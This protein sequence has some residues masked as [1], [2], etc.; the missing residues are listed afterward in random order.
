MHRTPVPWCLSFDRMRIVRCSVSIGLLACSLAVHASIFGDIKGLVHD[1]QHRPVAGAQITVKAIA[2]DWQKTASSDREGS[3]DIQ[4]V[5]IGQYQVTVTM[6]GF[7]EQS[8]TVLLRSG[9]ILDLHFALTVAQVKEQVEVHENQTLVDTASSTTSSTVE[10]QQITTTPGAERANSLAMITDFVPG[11]YVVHDQLHV[12]GGH[13]STWMLDGIPLPNTN[14]ATNVGPQIDP[15][16]IDTLEVQRG[17]LSAEYGDRIYGVFNAVTRSGFEASRQCDL[18]M[19]YGSYNQTDDQFSCGSH[20]E[21]FAY[22]ASL[23]G[24]RSD[25][26]LETPSP[27]VIH[28]MGAGLGGFLSL[29][30]NRTPADQLRFVASVRG[31][32]YQIPNTPEQQADGIRDVEDERD[33]FLNASWVHSGQNGLLFTLAPF[34]HLNRA[35][36]LGGPNDTPIS[37]ED[38]TR[39]DYAGGVTMLSLARGRHNAH[40]GVQAFAQREQTF[41]SVRSPGNP[42]LTENDTSW[43]STT[44]AF[45]E[46][47]FKATSWLTFNGG[48]RL[49]HFSGLLAETSLDPRIGAAIVLPR[50]R[51]V[52]RGFYGRYYQA[53][54][55]TTVSGPFLD[56]ASIQGFG[57]LPLRGE[58]DE[59]YEFGLAIPFR[60]WTLDTDYFHTAARNYFDHDVLGNSNIFLPLT[61]DHALVRGSEVTLRSPRLFHR[62]D[63]HVAYSHQWAVGFGGVSGGLVDLSAIPE[64]SFF[65]DHD[66]RDTLTAGA[67]V[68][69]PWRSWASVNVGYGSGFLNGDGPGHLPAHASADL[70][71]GKTINEQWSV[72]LTALNI[73]NNHYLLDNSNTFGGT[74]FVD[75]RTVAGQVRYT[76]HY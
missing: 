53:P 1:P 26:G 4:A 54:P 9:E 39:S 21:R 27:Q 43:G 12:R 62:A 45:V 74:H 24:N 63:L 13:Q 68:T 50:V 61:I 73:S 70:A 10:R 31:D 36:Y 37:P 71:L 6:S 22:F 11:A 72:R 44:S 34:V 35:H 42:G 20:T 58:K 8:R 48:L 52:L 5:P 40:F 56:L 55:L 14:I 18:A 3:F 29:I 66:Q 64:E 76:F 38:D 47:Q 67:T 49:T 65:L 46:D 59:Q 16:N 25:L 2:S 28:D 17:G 33:V 19:N 41:F 75:P 60:G 23:T 15:K 69:L 7:Q 32:H 30:F 57:F 51:W